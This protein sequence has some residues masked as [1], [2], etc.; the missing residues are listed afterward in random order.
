MAG[1]PDVLGLADYTCGGGA[2]RCREGSLEQASDAGEALAHMGT[3]DALRGRVLPPA[4]DDA[5]LRNA[6]RDGSRRGISTP[7]GR[8][9]PEC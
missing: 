4:D 7:R 6:L 1:E 2:V 8:V 3:A 9:P 5:G